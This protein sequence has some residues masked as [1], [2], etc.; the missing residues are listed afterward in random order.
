MNIYQNAS[1]ATNVW[2]GAVVMSTSRKGRALVFK[3]KRRRVPSHHKG[4]CEV[5]PSPYQGEAPEAETKTDT[6]GV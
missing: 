4:P 1:L 6:F 5:R 2:D 3:L